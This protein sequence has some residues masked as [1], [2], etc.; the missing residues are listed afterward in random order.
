MKLHFGRA[1]RRSFMLALSA[2]ALTAGVSAAY[3]QS[4]I[5]WMH[6]EPNPE[7]L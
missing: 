6:L 5:K 7:R 2:I 4:T 1:T 3:A